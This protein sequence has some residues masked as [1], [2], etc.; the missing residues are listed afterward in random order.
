MR[1]YAL[2][3]CAVQ[4]SEPLLTL[5]VRVNQ[6]KVRYEECSNDKLHF[7]PAT[8]TGV[9]NG[10]ITV[11]T[12]STDLNGLAWQSCGSIATTGASGISRDYTMIVCPDA[13]DFGGAAAWGQAPG[14]ISWYRSMYASAPIVQV[15]EAVSFDSSTFVTI[16]STMI[17][18]DLC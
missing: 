3:N 10:V 6:Q 7:E 15:H 9:N 17:G 1:T 2:N 13:V 18:I 12:I 14:S 4:T 8:G 5:S 11:N 16:V